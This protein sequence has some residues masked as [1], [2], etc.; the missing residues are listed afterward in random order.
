MCLEQSNSS[1]VFLRVSLIVF[2]FIVVTLSLRQTLNYVLMYLNSCRSINEKEKKVLSV[3]TD[4]LRIERF[5][6]KRQRLKYC[7]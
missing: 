5:T 3:I 4:T 6:W 7:T 2:Y 1:S